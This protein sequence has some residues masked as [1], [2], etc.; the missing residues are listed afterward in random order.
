[1][2]YP[3]KILRYLE[4]AMRRLIDR[5]RAMRILRFLDGDPLVAQTFKICR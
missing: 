3:S 4:L 5:D 2:F 1:M